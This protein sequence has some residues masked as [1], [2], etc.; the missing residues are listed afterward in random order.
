MAHLNLAKLLDAKVETSPYQYTIVPGF[1]SAQS[2]SR[3]NATYPDIKAG[4]S[5]PIDMKLTRGD[6]LDVK[7]KHEG[8]VVDSGKKFLGICV[9]HRAVIGTGHGPESRRKIG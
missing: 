2:I 4:G 8:R 9:G 1:L 6:L 5:F 7:V 3:V